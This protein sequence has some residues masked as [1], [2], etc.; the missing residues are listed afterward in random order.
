MIL[1]QRVRPE[2]GAGDRPAYMSGGK[3]AYTLS[4]L[5]AE[6]AAL[7]TVVPAI[8]NGTSLAQELSRRAPA[9][10]QIRQL[11]RC[12]FFSSFE[13]AEREKRVSSW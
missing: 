4:L 12:V 10:R 8:N 9:S 13:T 11:G 1:F 5:P 3:N 2:S 6:T 7:A